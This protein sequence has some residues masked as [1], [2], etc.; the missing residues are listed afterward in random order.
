MDPIPN[1]QT[2][3]VGTAE[4]TL[5]ISHEAGVPDVTGDW[6]LVRA[7]A[8]SANPVDAKMIGAKSYMTPGAIS[9]CDFAGEVVAAGP[10]ADFQV[11][12]RVC[13]A[14]MGMNS[15]LPHIGAFATYVG[16]SSTYALRIPPTMSYTEA[17]AIGISFLTTVLALFW[18]LEL[19]GSPT[20]P[21]SSS[22]R[23]IHVLVSGGATGSGTAALQLLRVAG[24]TPIATSSPHHFDLCKSYGTEVVFDYNTSNCAEDIRK[25]TKNNLR[26]ALDCVTS[27]ES[28][29]LC[30]A[31]LGRAGGAYTG[32]DPFSKEVSETR[33]GIK[34]D[35]VLGPTMMGMEIGW[36]EPHYRAVDPDIRAFGLS[37]RS[38]IEDLFARGILKVHPIEERDG[39]LQGVLG[40]LE[41]IKNGQVRG[42][43][44]VYLMDQ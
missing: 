25:Y 32:L 40:G 24:F 13:G 2:A 30:Y 34:A 18:S 36:P 27:V 11:G 43:N 9:G 29:K 33:K 41:E 22:K 10:D 4:G 5:E 20:E 16:A 21:L 12:D 14:L 23:P 42:K 26:Y 39:G 1:V 7:K 31:A 19:P 37:F 15:L 44:L 28:M 35:W 6:I 3:I 8:V 38:T 17:S